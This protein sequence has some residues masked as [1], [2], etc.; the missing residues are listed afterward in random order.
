MTIIVTPIPRLIDL[1]VPAFTLGVAN[2]AGSA[3]TAVSSNSTLLAFDTTAVDA[4]TFGQSGSVGSATVAPRRDH[5]HAME[6]ASVLGSTLVNESRTAAAATGDVSYTGAG[7][8]PTTILVWA[9]DN[10]S[11]TAASWGYADDAANDTVLAIQSINAAGAF[12][13]HNTDKIA[14]ISDAH[15]TPTNGQTAL[16]KSIDADGV[17]LT[18][19][20]FGTGKAVLIDFLYMATAA[21]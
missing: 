13:S 20:K 19:T 21:P 3:E 18:W 7:F 17:T 5:A 11:G 15:P 14:F 1:A 8:R 2:A 4:I 10:S 9:R 12:I 6:A 16:L